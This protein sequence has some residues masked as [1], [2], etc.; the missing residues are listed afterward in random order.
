MELHYGL[1]PG[2]KLTKAHVL[3]QINSK[4]FTNLPSGNVIVCELVLRNGYS[5]RGEAAVA[6]PKNFVQALGEKYAYQDAVRK[7]WPLE[8]YLLKEALYQQQQQLQD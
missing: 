1:P 6:D 3:S 7:I 4:T 2:N 5:V 8:G